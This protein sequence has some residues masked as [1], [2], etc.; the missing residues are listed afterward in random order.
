M[1]HGAEEREDTGA[2]LELRERNKGVTSPVLL[3]DEEETKTQ[4]ADNER[5]QGMRVVPG[6]YDRSLHDGHENCH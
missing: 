3:V 4:D 6:V 1:Q 5:R 2:V